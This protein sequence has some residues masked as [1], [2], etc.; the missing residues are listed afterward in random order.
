MDAPAQNRR[1]VE[2]PFAL[3]PDVETSLDLPHFKHTW[4]PHAKGKL[5]SCCLRCLAIIAVGK[6]EMTL[7]AAEHKHRCGGRSPENDIPS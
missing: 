1:Q 5:D 4:S 6:D 7:L 2:P 3:S